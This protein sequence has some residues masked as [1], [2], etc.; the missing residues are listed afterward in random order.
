M[1][2]ILQFGINIDDDAI[3]KVVENRVS[4]EIKGELKQS[5][6]D[7]L[8]TKWGEFTPLCKE[9]MGELLVEYKE[10]IISKASEDVA[11]SLKRSKKYKE[12]LAS[13]VEEM[14]K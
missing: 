10:E 6:K 12:A 1:E 2:H 8:F 4:N 13:I 14:E 7:K 5:I 9:L 3:I 11:N